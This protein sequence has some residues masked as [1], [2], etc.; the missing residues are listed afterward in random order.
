MMKK[1]SS[2]SYQ[3]EKSHIPDSPR[4]KEISSNKELEE[5]I[6]S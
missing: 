1:T 4:V 3:M 6:I 2:L 5:M